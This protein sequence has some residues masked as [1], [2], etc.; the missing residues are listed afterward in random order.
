MDNKSIAEV[1]K[2]AANLSEIHGLSETRSKSLHV[3][4]YKIEQLNHSLGSLPTEKIENLPGIGKS[5]ANKIL[6]ILRTGS[7]PE[8]DKL[9]NETPVGIFDIMGIPGCGPKKIFTLWKEGQIETVDQLLEACDDGRLEQLKGF[10][11]K[12]I[13]NLKETILYIK[14]NEQKLHY[15]KAELL[16]ENILKDFSQR[17]PEIMV[18][19]T[20]K[21]RRRWNVIDNLEFLI[22]ELKNEDI[23]N[24][25]SGHENIE[26]DLIKSGPFTLRGKLLSPTINLTVRFCRPEQYFSQLVILTGSKEHLNTPV[27]RSDKLIYH[28]IKHKKFNSEEEIYQQLG[29][30]FIVPDIREGQFEI[31]SAK[32]GLL[33]TL[34][35]YEDLKGILH[36]HSTYSDGKNTLREMAEYCQKL[37]YEYLGI[38]DHSKTAYY[39]GGLKEEDIIRQHQEIQ[40]INTD[41]APFRVFK[42]IESDILADGNLDYDDQVL[43]TFDFIVASIHTGYN[44]TQKEATQRL[45]K[46][47][48]NPHT[49]ILGHL[50]ARLLLERKGYPVD[51]KSIID[52]C[53]QNQVVIEM[54]A[55]PYRL[56]MDWRYIHIALEKG[57]KISINPDAHDTMGYHNMRYGWIAARKGGLTRDM[58]FNALSKEEINK[59]FKSKNQS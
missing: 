34:V 49:T 57:V 38:S 30:P 54:N 19:S 42:G 11:K 18:S 28:E 4:A 53:A 26:T 21:L 17:F 9:A 56:D 5:T 31:E 59:Y 47:I 20:G 46:A 12:T 45:I 8:L 1:F 7:Y 51:H 41:L 6:E 35:E 37:G 16:S 22:G 24:F 50:T 29:L 39:A 3:T 52:A 2:Q 40:Q 13:L 27:H 58:T 44:M 32:K 10:G 14:S 48:E 36:N 23:S 55:S 33:P 43:K 25:F 15:V